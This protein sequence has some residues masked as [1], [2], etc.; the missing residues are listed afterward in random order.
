VNAL[1]Y[2]YI[3]VNTGLES[4]KFFHSE[5]RNTE[6]STQLASTRSRKKLKYKFQA[7]QL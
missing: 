5:K 2:G 3:Q 4:A 1:N 7:L 6:T